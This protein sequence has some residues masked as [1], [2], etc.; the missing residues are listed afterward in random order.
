MIALN[1]E[2]L[3]FMTYPNGET[4][5]DG[6]HILKL[7]ESENRISFKY[8]TD[9][10]LLKLLFVKS[11]LD[12]HRYKASLIISYMPYSRMDRVEGSSVFTLKYTAHMINAMNFER[13]TIIEPHSDVST[14]LIHRSEAIY[15]TGDLL[16]Q[17]MEETG[18]QTGRD[19]LFFPDA[20]AQK[21]YG[22]LG[23]YRQLVG[24]KKRNF[25]T[26]QIEHLDVVGTVGETGFKAIIVDDLCSYGGTF[27]LSAERLRELGASEVYL[28]VSHC[29]DSIYKGK[30]PASGLID[31]VYTTDTILS[32]TGTDLI[33]MFPIGGM[34]K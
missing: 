18:F 6:E 28:L 23:G 33:K 2:Q 30:L 22:K 12:D 31:R 7:A 21:R 9:G 11:F 25:E 4:R 1:G 27:L 29:E 13:V 3:T 32:Q 34:Y 20:G 26:G 24:F 8:E 17:V 16:Q 19:Y 5:V 15:P 14:A 10:D